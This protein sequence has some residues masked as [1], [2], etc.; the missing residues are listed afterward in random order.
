MHAI[1]TGVMPADAYAE[2]ESA[3]RKVAEAELAG[4]YGK[5]EALL[6][7]AENLAPYNVGGRR[8]HA[9]WMCEFVM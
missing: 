7:H 9:G 6:V 2:A 4:D 1:E 3:L 8:S 5:A